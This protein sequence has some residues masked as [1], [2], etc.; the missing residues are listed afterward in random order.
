MAEL[1]A[2]R[3]YAQLLAGP[4]ADSVVDV[5]RR[6]LAVHAQDPRGARLAIRARSA[7]LS[8]RDIDEALSVDRSL[9]ISSLNRGTLHLVRSEDYWWLRDLTTPQLMAGAM[10]RLE[11]EQVSGEA[12]DRGVAAIER[13]LADHGPLTRDQLRQ[14]LSGADVA[15]AGQRLMGLIFLATVR[16]LIVRGPM[17]GR[18]QA[19]VRVADWLGPAPVPTDRSTALGELARR[20]LAAHGPATDADLAKWAGITL[21]NARRGLTEISSQLVE[22]DDGLAALADRSGHTQLPPPRLLGSFDPSLF[23]WISRE[24]II[25]HHQS[26]VTANAIFRPFAM[27]EGRAVATWALTEGAVVVSPMG[28][29]PAAV[30][31]ALDLD[32][33]DVL[34]FLA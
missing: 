8:A 27:V 31:C 9:V 16:G 33:A 7:G 2:A 3:L 28:P 1:L 32:A 17:V 21:G 29:I 4:P 6:L 22:R 12:A 19:F 15:T 14:Q 20:Y 24:P 25:G 23:G 30:T 13:A 18:N 26:V 5:V 11:I 34:R 10:R